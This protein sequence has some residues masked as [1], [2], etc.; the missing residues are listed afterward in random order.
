[1]SV[2][3]LTW[4]LKQD[5]GGSGTKLVLLLLANYADA[6]GVSWYSQKYLAEV[7]ELT[8]RTI[9]TN[10]KKLETAG[11][12]VRE[13]RARKDGSRSTDI[14][15]LRMGEGGETISPPVGKPE[16]PGCGSERG[17]G[18]E[19]RGGGI[20]EPSGESS[21]EPSLTDTMHRVWCEVTGHPQAEL[22]PTRSKRYKD[23]AKQIGKIA[24]EA[25]T[26]R[27]W[28]VM[29][30]ALWSDPWRH[31]LMNRHDP[32][33][34]LVKVEQRESWIE[35]ALTEISA[36][37]DGSTYHQ[38]KEGNGNGQVPES[39]EIARKRR[40]VQERREAAEETR[41]KE[42]DYQA[43]LDTAKASDWYLALPIKEQAKV[44]EEVGER[45]ARDFPGVPETKMLKKTVFLNLW[46]ERTAA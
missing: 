46:R 19:T 40:A 42:E 36:G 30:K 28:S 25:D 6:E 43:R 5:T 44:E 24:P 14:C 34:V 17:V 39:V 45:L 3:A 9:T 41:A 33:S 13:E 22:S 7:G 2:E 15:R 31:L 16:P 37:R 21:Y 38:P 20:L 29:V 32:V 12:L 11:L 8:K 1:M 26:I 4:A 18:G 27:V 10:L 23:T 35:V